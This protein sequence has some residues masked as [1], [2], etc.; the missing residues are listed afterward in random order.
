MNDDLRPGSDAVAHLPA[1]DGRSAQYAFAYSSETRLF[2][3]AR[4]VPSSG[5]KVIVHSLNIGA[6]SVETSDE[7]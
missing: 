6:E 2:A 7:C 3:S 5:T 1:V 4:P